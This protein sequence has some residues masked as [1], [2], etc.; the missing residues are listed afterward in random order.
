MKTLFLL[1]SLIY[2][3]SCLAI[4]Q[5]KQDKLSQL[6]TTL[7]IKHENN[8][9]SITKAYQ[10]FRRKPGTERWQAKELNL[11]KEKKREVASLLDSISVTK[12]LAP[13]S[14]KFDYIL[15]LGGTIAR[16]EKRV[17]TIIDLTNSGLIFEE[18]IILTSQRPLDPSID[19]INSLQKKSAIFYHKDTKHISPPNTETEAAKML[20]AT[21]PLNNYTKKIRYID[22]PRTLNQGFWQRGNTRDTVNAWLN[23]IPQPGRV[24]VI[25]SQPH[26]HYQYEVV[27]SVLPDTFTIEITADKMD[28]NYP[29]ITQLD[30]IAL[31]L[32]N[33]SPEIR[34]PSTS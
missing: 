4:D 28:S 18:L 31:W 6:L 23:T 25:S 20:V 19:T 30:A 7:D 24:L 3:L 13:K 14:K 8:L 17:N 9:S 10:I 1:L 22:T 12:H 5:Q 32:Y 33:L 26:A 16:M 11:S 21:S 2:A 27:K 15:L 34:L 29:L